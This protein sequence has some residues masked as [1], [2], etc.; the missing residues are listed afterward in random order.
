MSRINT[1]QDFWMR[2][3]R[4]A[5]DECWLWQGCP[6]DR[7]YGHFKINCKRYRAHVFAFEN[8]KI[9]QSQDSVIMHTCN[10]P[11]CCNPKHLI[12]GTQT[13]NMQHAVK[14]SS[15]PSGASGISGISYGK[16]IKQYCAR[17]V[18]DNIRY[19]L[20]TGKDLSEAIYA[21]KVWTF[22]RSTF[23]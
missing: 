20:Y 6:N 21:Q 13:E 12:E 18:L 14:S 17:A 4:G 10:T 3:Q 16:R 8:T 11:L 5:E 19:T 9:R 2:V 23:I 7:G 22:N 1:E 15:W